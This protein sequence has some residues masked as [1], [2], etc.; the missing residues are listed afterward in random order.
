MPAVARFRRALFAR[1]A[2]PWSAWTRWATTPLIL[3]PVWRR[4]WRDAAWISV[5]FALNPIIFGKP[6]DTSAW[7]TRAML[8]EEQWII[9]RPRDA[10]LVVNLAGGA[11][12]ALALLNARRRRWRP[13][14]IA[15]AAAMALTMGYWALMVRYF[16]R[17]R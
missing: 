5:W 12:T 15:T 16:D 4:S 7:S 3:V 1:H 13:T 2:S 14:V 10:A 11:A 8:G 9:A 6:A 17:R